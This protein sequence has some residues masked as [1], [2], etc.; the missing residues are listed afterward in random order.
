MGWI[1]KVLEDSEADGC[2]AVDKNNYKL[3]IAWDGVDKYFFPDYIPMTPKALVSKFMRE[4][5][6]FYM[7]RASSVLKGY[8]WSRYDHMIPIATPPEQSLANIDTRLDWDIT[9]FLYHHYG[10]KEMFDKLEKKLD[11]A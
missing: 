3:A 5:G 10:Y 11:A 8:P 4:N 1:D 2:L 6:T 9:E 7:F